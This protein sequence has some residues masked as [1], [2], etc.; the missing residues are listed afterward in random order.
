VGVNPPTTLQ[1]WL[2]AA[3]DV[4]D[5]ARAELDARELEVLL[6]V[7]ATK[8]AILSAARLLDELRRAG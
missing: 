8:I 1:T 2:V 3:L 5:G 7:L 4:L 6:D